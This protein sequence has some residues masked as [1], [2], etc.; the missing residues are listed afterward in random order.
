MKRS[1]L[2]EVKSVIA[3]TEKDF[4]SKR[5]LNSLPR[6]RILPSSQGREASPQ[7]SIWFGPQL[8]GKRKTARPF[9]AGAPME[10]KFSS[11]RARGRWSFHHPSNRKRIQDLLREEAA[12]SSVRLMRVSM[13]GEGVLLIKLETNEREHLSRFLRILAGRIPRM[14]TGAERGR[15]LNARF[16][17]GLAASRC[18]PVTRV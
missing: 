5:N 11:V 17:S 9:Q 6:D 12:K 2:T 1:K 18:V 4:R 7:K 13:K 10:I 3:R 8:L 15:P 16:W 14:V